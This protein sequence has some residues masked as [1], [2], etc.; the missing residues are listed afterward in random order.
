MLRKKLL[1]QNNLL[2]GLKYTGVQWP[3]ELETEEPHP[4]E[5]KRE[6]YEE[7][8]SIQKKREIYRNLKIVA[9]ENNDAPQALVFYAKEMEA[10]SHTL[11]WKKGEVIDKCILW[12]N[13]WTNNFG[14]SWVRP[15]GLILGAG[16]VLYGLLLWSL[17]LDIGNYDN[18][19][20]FPAFL[21]PTHKAGTEFIA[22]QWGFLAYS[23]D[24]VFD[25]LKQR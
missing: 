8:N 18:W 21:I 10:Y 1:S 2:S 25:S 24:L 3:G 14:L 19:T 6:A 23:I 7:P 13:R 15:I 9:L 12:F 17:C 20:K 22:G 4:A 11:S 5:R 16:I